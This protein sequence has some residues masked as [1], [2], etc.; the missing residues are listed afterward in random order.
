MTAHALRD[1]EQLAQLGLTL[2]RHQS[3][4]S[5]DFG[6]YITK[7]GDVAPIANLLLYVRT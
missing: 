3:G 2:R 7:Q 4:T 1:R 5:L 6:G